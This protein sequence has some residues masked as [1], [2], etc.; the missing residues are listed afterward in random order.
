MDSEAAF[1][2]GALADLGC[3]GRR[4]ECRLFLAGLTP[5]GTEKP[6]EVCQSRRSGETHLET[7]GAEIL[8]EGGDRNL[9]WA[10][11]SPST[12]L[13]NSEA[14]QKAVLKVWFSQSHRAEETRLSQGEAVP[15]HTSLSTKSPGGL[16]PGAGEN[17]LPADFPKLQ[18]SLNSAQC[19]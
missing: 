15:G 18:P 13:S 2:Q 6:T 19:N 17:Q 1:S 12:Y 11:V 4:W 3:R 9:S 10:P 5:G 7:E 14:K 16:S 8:G